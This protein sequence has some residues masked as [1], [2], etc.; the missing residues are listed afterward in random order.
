MLEFILTNEHTDSGEYNLLPS[1]RPK[2]NMHKT[3]TI[4]QALAEGSNYL[5]VITKQ[6]KLFLMWLHRLYIVSDL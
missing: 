1:N 2:P 4:L 6:Q 3:N 5:F